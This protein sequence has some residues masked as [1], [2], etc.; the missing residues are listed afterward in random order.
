MACFPGCYKCKDAKV[1]LECKPGL[2]LLAEG[3]CACSLA[4]Y[5]RTTESCQSC[6]KGYFAYNNSCVACHVNCETCT[7]P[8]SSECI[9]CK[10]NRGDTNFK[11][12]AGIC[13]CWPGYTNMLNGVCN[14]TNSSTPAAAKGV[15]GASTATAAVVAIASRKAILLYK[16]ADF[17]Q[18]TGSLTYMNVNYPGNSRD[19]L[20]TLNNLNL[21]PLQ[22]KSASGDD[23]NA[24][25]RRGLLISP[26]AAAQ[27]KTE[28][29]LTNAAILIGL[30]IFSWA[31]VWILGCNRERILGMDEGWGKYILVKLLENTVYAFPIQIFLRTYMDGSVNM[32][33]QLASPKWNGLGIV[34]F[35][36]A[37]IFLGYM[38]F[39]LA[40]FVK[41]IDLARMEENV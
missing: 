10:L 18:S 23:Q 25:A 34:N 5:N 32:F 27:G 40:F 28:L 20:N 35:I 4:L 21:S 14:I 36:C 41:K 31:S 12:V 26:I 2:D 7:G 15:V 17:A 29:F 1:C 38:I 39:L 24:T 3:I 30:T 33:I 8:L 11:P 13:E 22:G 37:L 6:V 16:F 19:I 9:S